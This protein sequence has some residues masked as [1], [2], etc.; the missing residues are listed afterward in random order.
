MIEDWITRLR[1]QQRS[2]STREALVGIEDEFAQGEDRAA[3]IAQPDQ[4]AVRAQL[5]QDPETRNTALVHVTDLTGNATRVSFARKKLACSERSIQFLRA[6]GLQPLR[7]R[8]GASGG[9]GGSPTTLEVVRAGLEAAVAIV[10]L[11]T[12]DELV[13]LR[14]EL[15]ASGNRDEGFQPRP[16]VLLEGGMAL[17]LAPQ[18]TLL[19]RIGRIREISDISG[20]NFISLS[21]NPGDRVR[22]FMRLEAAGCKPVSNEDFV[23]PAVAG[24]FDSAM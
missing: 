10:V 9:R 21:N 18:R 14:A 24:D 16:N 3:F 8:S 20:I 11:L 7:G 23:D 12:P 6:V 13:S 19:V 5:A 2:T 1:R 17:A 4:E 15:A 22:F